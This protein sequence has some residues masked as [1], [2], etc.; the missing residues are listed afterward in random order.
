MKKILKKN[1]II[2]TALVVMVAIAGYLSMTDREELTMN[3]RYIL[4]KNQIFLS[5]KRQK[6]GF[7]AISQISC[8]INYT[9]KRKEITSHEKN[10]MHSA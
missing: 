5:K 4:T 8:K 3:K 10:I 7:L 6:N 1:Q 2:I 9:Y